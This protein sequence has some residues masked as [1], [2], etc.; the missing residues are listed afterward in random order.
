MIRNR[1][2]RTKLSLLVLA[3]VLVMLTLGA[4]VVLPAL[5]DLSDANRSSEIAELV[6][7]SMEYRDAVE[8]ER[9]TTI[10]N[11]E[12]GDAQAQLVTTRG[13]ADTERGLLFDTIS[14]SALTSDAEIAGKIDGLIT[15][16]E[17]LLSLRADIDSGAITDGTTADERF[18]ELLGVQQ[19]FNRV[20]G[21]SGD[22]EL[23][24]R[25]DAIT[26]YYDAE[27]ALSDIGGF[28]GSRLDGEFDVASSREAFAL[29]T[30]EELAFDQFKSV[31]ESADIDLLTAALN[32]EQHELFK[33]LL[34]DAITLGND[35]GVTGAQWWPATREIFDTVNVVEQEVFERFVDRAD[36]ARSEARST[37]LL[38]GIG[39][40]VVAL[41]AITAAF[42]LGRSLATRVRRL[43]DDAK[44]AATQQ[45]P[46]VLAS[47]QDTDAA[48]IAEQLPTIASGGSDEIGELAESFNTVLRTAVETSVDH[49]QKRAATMTS[50]LLSLGRRNQALI[51]RQLGVLDD[52]E[53]RVE[54]PSVLE[55]LFRVDH[56]LTRLRRNSENLLVLA[57]ERPARQWTEPVPLLDII[58]GATSE[59]ESL[60]RVDIN[61]E[62][63]ARRLVAGSHAVD[64][65]HVVAELIDNSLSYSP[66][67]S[68]V[69]LRASE[70]KGLVR[71]WVI[72]RGVGMTDGEIADANERIAEPPNIAEV[73]AD[74]VGFQVVGR[75][76]R[77][78]GV[79]VMIHT[80]PGGGLAASIDLAADAFVQ[81]GDT[82][83]PAPPSISPVSEE[84]E[85]IIDPVNAS[86]QY[87]ARPAMFSDTAVE[88]TT[89]SA[90]EAEAVMAMEPAQPD[91]TPSIWT[92]A[93]I[94][95]VETASADIETMDADPANL[96]EPAGFR[97]R[98]P[99]RAIADSRHGAGPVEN[100]L[101][102]RLP[103]TDQTDE[104]ETEDPIAQAE[105]RR[106]AMSG[107]QAGVARGRDPQSIAAEDSAVDTTTH[108]S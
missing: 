73:V 69:A 84:P 102:R 101:H 48:G 30:I 86:V 36:A 62:G 21:T 104:A 42:F 87:V 16:A 47:V 82:W 107:L 19:D 97:K 60:E 1:S 46:H 3:P 32:S 98:V 9:F 20:L 26:A 7:A 11:I 24:R 10:Q 52:L 72:D 18:Q 5:G 67:N 88:S 8:H 59:V 74:Q 66:P 41:T 75:L 105:R 108:L 38:F 93:P 22:A 91:P 28:I 94:V 49:V 103:T 85:A 64:L 15:A 37:A 53:S 65:S 55:D 12:T 77:R 6:L 44:D 34:D 13:N 54:D 40:A 83:V 57:S 4:G 14:A 61:L 80:N 56:M 51:D 92:D 45:L 17:G 99:G 78:L 35:A 29:E 2:I 106:Q 31:G 23:V 33:Q 58:R 68:M 79:T 70:A 43:S 81:P 25:G 71:I 90:Q 63:S 100:G 39:S 27:E 50:I 96:F 95:S 89:P 76:S